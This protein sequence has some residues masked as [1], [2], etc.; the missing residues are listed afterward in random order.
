LSATG[1]EVRHDPT[2]NRFSVVLDGAEAELA[3]VRLDGRMVIEHT[4]VP[5]AHRGRGIAAILMEAALAFCREH[6]LDVEARCSYAASYLKRH[7]QPP[8]R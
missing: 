3:Y 8:R 5:P 1:T 6:G 4:G 7:P 2:A